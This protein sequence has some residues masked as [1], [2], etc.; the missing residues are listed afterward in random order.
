MGKHLIGF[1]ILHLT[2]FSIYNMGHPVTPQFIKEIQA[3]IFMTGILLGVMSLAQFIFAPFWGQISDNFGRKI[4]FI[5]PL[6]YAFG[7]IG[8][9]VLEDPI[10]LLL[11]RFIAGG[12]AI[13]TTTVHFAY[14]SD[15]A[16]PQHKM[17]ALGIASLLLPIGVF[18]GYTVGGYIGDIVSP[19]FTFL[20]QAIFSVIMSIILFFYVNPPKPSNE[21]K[22][23]F[24][25]I[26]WNI[27]KENKLLLFRN[28]DTSLK[29]VLLI[30]FLNIISFQMIVSQASVILNDGFNK[31]TIYIGLFVAFFNLLAGIISF[32]IQKG[33][34]S[35]I[36]TTILPY[37]S[38]T[39]A[40]M[41]G[42]SLFTILGNPLFMFVGMM[43]ATILNTIFIA[44]IQHTIVKID[45]HNEKGAL[46]G[47][48]QSVQSLGVFTGA[49][50][51]GLVLAQYMFAPFVFALIFFIIT[52]MVNIY[53]TKTKHKL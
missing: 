48:N 43:I 36:N 28:K 19:R 1:L 42:L 2:I 46:I 6:G 17:L 11:F 13:I 14:V 51:A 4:A 37:L 50:L 15:I 52:F 33:L 21:K 41:A 26:K 45:L 25:D 47:I 3:P 44:L 7:Q 18:F 27:Y 22:F 35:K 40:F 8:F 9:I 29:F 10:T 49:S 16:K 38:L 34:S 53:L 23:S 5:G 24:K 12:F 20:M 39:S 31:T 32:I 30:T